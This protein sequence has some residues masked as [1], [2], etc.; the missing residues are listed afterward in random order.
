[1]VTVL[2]GTQTDLQESPEQI[3]RI[4]IRDRWNIN[5]DGYIP[6]RESIQFSL[7]GWTG[8]KSYQIGIE[9]FNAPILTQLNIGI[10]Q[11][12]RYR[13]PI[14]V[15]VWMIKHHDVPPPQLHHIT[16]KVEQIIRENINSVGFGITSIVLTSPFSRINEE[17]AWSGNF[18]NQTQNTLYHTVA[19]V[20]LHYTRVTY[21][22]K[23]NVRISKTHK[24]NV[25]IEEE[26]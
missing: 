12:T 3:T 18:P 24:Y 10:E 14:L 21:G 4:F 15:H 13:D 2:A 1:M 26:I 17:K 23:T 19:T 7:F 9:P 16:Q 20:E 22:V 11:W 25:E 5:Q 6:A 8:R